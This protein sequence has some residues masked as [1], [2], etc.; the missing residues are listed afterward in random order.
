MVLGRK[1]LMSHGRK[2]AIVMRVAIYMPQDLYQ[3]TWVES[4]SSLQ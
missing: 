3:S 2:N 1:R 4:R